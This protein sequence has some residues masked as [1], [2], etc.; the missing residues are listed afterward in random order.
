MHPIETG[1]DFYHIL[2]ERDPGL[3]SAF[4]AVKAKGMEDWVYLLTL[5]IGSHAGVP[6]LRNVERIANKIV[7]PQ[8][9]ESFGDGEIF[10][11]LCAIFLHDIGKTI[12]KDD[13]PG[14]GRKDNCTIPDGD[15]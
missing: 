13:D 3:A 10:L 9:K 12:P 1:K 5:E 8:M 15:P 14:C 11:L 2:L 7:P 4:E 6:H